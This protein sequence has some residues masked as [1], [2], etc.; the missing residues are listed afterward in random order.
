V[1]PLSHRAAAHHARASAVRVL[2]AGRPAAR[3]RLTLHIRRSPRPCLPNSLP[4][5]VRRR[6]PLILL[7]ICPRLWWLEYPRGECVEL[8]RERS[9]RMHFAVV[10]GGLAVGLLNFGDKV[11]LHFCICV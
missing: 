6:A 2:I 7:H 11:R 3:T 9:Y 5:L 8:I 4:E 10:L 1:F